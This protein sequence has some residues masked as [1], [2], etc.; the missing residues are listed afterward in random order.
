MSF[1]T[2]SFAQAGE[3]YSTDRNNLTENDGLGS[4]NYAG[5][6]FYTNSIKRGSFTKDGTLD[7]LGESRFRKKAFFDSLLTAFAIQ[8]QT[9]QANSITVV[10]NAEIGGLLK[11]G[12]TLNFDGSNSTISSL[13]GNISFNNNDLTTTGKIR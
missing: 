2:N 8:V 3:K 5:L 6:N 13:S 4:K 1:S 10:Y 12:N 9:I 11:V 7:I